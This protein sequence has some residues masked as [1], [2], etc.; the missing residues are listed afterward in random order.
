M[1]FLDRK[2][3]WKRREAFFQS[4]SS[5]FAIVNYFAVRLRLKTVLF[6]LTEH[7]ECL[8]SVCTLCM[9]IINLLHKL[10]IHIFFLFLTN[11][12]L[13]ACESVQKIAINSVSTQ[14]LNWELRFLHSL[15]LEKI[16]PIFLLHLECQVSDWQNSKEKKT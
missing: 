7:T 8:C 16:Y 5:S 15:N 12:W 3:M 4:L 1:N 6:S 14:S 10:H 11:Q 2:L 13:R 9:Y